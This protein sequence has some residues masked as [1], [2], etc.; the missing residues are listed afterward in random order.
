M[1]SVYKNVNAQRNVR[2]WCL[3]RIDAWEVEHVRT[4]V[5]T[6]AGSTSVLGAGPADDRAPGIVLVPGTNMNAA[7]SLS[8]AGM[9][10][11]RRRTIVLDVPGQPGLSSGGR[12]VRGRMGWYGKWLGEVLEQV[13]PGPVV[14]VGHSLGGAIALACGSGRIAGRVLLSTAGLSRARV[15]PALLAATVPWLARPSLS[16]AAGLLRHMA[17]PDRSLSPELAEW[18]ALV[19]RECRSSL[20]P[21]PLPRTVVERRRSV[22]CLV[23]TGRHDAFFPPPALSAAVRDRLGTECRVVEGAGHLLLDEEPAAVA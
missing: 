13:T 21:A 6:S 8:V 12:P 7:L 11:A 2:R 10:A 18:M 17:A 9:L 23:A 16:R 5:T 20:A 14:V 3:E 19:A 15:S 4:E 1:P 22:P